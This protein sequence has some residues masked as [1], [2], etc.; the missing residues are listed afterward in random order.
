MKYS[1]NGYKRNSKDRNNPY[2]IIPS[3]NITMEGVDFPVLGTDNLGN[4]KLMMPGTNYVFPGNTVFEIPLAQGG[5]ETE[6][7]TSSDEFNKLNQGYLL[8]QTAYN[9]FINE[10]DT[11]RPPAGKKEK[12]ISSVL[13]FKNCWYNNSCVQTIKDVFNNAGIDS[14]IP[15]DVYDNLSFLKNYK[16][17]GFELI[18]NASEEDMR[19]GDII[20]F[21]YSEDKYPYH[22]GMYIADDQYISDGAHD[23]PMEKKSVS[24]K[25][26]YRVFR[27]L[28]FG[29]S[30]SKVQD[31]E[32]LDTVDLTDKKI[33]QTYYPDY[34]FYDLSKEKEKLIE[35]LQTDAF[36]DRY[37]KQYE[38]VTGNQ[39]TDEEYEQRLADQIA[40]I[41]GGSDMATPILYSK[42]DEGNIQVIASDDELAKRDGYGIYSALDETFLQDFLQKSRGHVEFLHEKDDQGEMILDENGNP[43]ITGYNI[44]LLGPKEW[45]A[46]ELFYGPDGYK[47]MVS[48]D[49]QHPMAHAIMQHELSHLY[50]T[51]YSPLWS[52]VE[53]YDEGAHYIKDIFGQ[54]QPWYDSTSHGLGHTKKIEEIGAGK[55]M[56][57]QALSDYGIWDPNEGEFTDKHLK[58]LNKVIRKNKDFLKD[59]RVGNYAFIDFSNNQGA[60]IDSP[61]VNQYLTSLGLSNPSTDYLSAIAGDTISGVISNRIMKSDLSDSLNIIDQYDSKY[62]SLST[63]K[64]VKSRDGDIKNWRWNKKRIREEDKLMDNFLSDKGIKNM[65]NPDYDI[66]YDFRGSFISD[67]MY[68]RNLRHLYGDG[69]IKDGKYFTSSD[70]FEQ[71][72]PG[73]ESAPEE[74]KEKYKEKFQELFAGGNL[75][76]L[77]GILNNSSRGWNYNRGNLWNEETEESIPY[78]GQPL[79]DED[80]AFYKDFET[81]FQELSNQ[82]KT[83]LYDYHKGLIDNQG[84][85]V[86]KYLNE[87]AMEEDASMDNTVMAKYGAELPKAQYGYDKNMVI[88]D[89]DVFNTLREEGYNP[90]DNS[91]NY[92]HPGFEQTTKDLGVY[93]NFYENPSALNFIGQNIVPAF[94]QAYLTATDPF[95]RPIHAIRG[96]NF[97]GNSLTDQLQGVEEKQVNEKE[98]RIS[99]NMPNWTT[100]EE[101][102]SLLNEDYEAEDLLL[103]ATAI[104]N[105]I[106][107]IVHGIEEAAEGDL[108][109]G[110]MYT[111]FGILPGTASP[112]VNKLRP[113]VGAL[114]DALKTGKSYKENLKART[115]A[116]E[117]TDAAKNPNKKELNSLIKDNQ[118]TVNKHL[119]EVSDPALNPFSLFDGTITEPTILSPSAI[120]NKFSKHNKFQDA[121]TIARGGDNNITLTRLQNAGGLTFKNGKVYI[122]KDPF[123]HTSHKTSTKT[124]E[125]PVDHKQVRNSTHFSSGAVLGH[126]AGDWG[127]KQVAIITNANTMKEAGQLQFLHPQDTWFYNKHALELPTEGSVILTRDKKLYNQILK[128]SPNYN[129]KF[130]GD[131]ID[132]FAKLEKERIKNMSLQEITDMFGSNSH[133]H[134]NKGILGKGQVFANSTEPSKNLSQWKIDNFLE[135][136][137]DYIIREDGM[138]ISRYTSKK[139]SPW[140]I[141]GL[142]GIDNTAEGYAARGKTYDEWN[143]AF[144]DDFRGTKNSRQIELFTQDGKIT[145]EALEIYMASYR[146]KIWNQMVNL[147]AGHALKVD[148]TLLKHPIHG[149]NYINNYQK[150][151]DEIMSIS[152]RTEE[153][154]GKK[155]INYYNDVLTDSEKANLLTG[156]EGII[157]R[158]EGWMNQHS[159]SAHRGSPLGDGGIESLDVHP[160][161]GRAVEVIDGEYVPYNPFYY[162]GK[163]NIP[164]YNK[165]PWATGF[166]NMPIEVQIHEVNKLKSVLDDD[167]FRQATSELENLHGMSWEELLQLPE[168]VN[169]KRKGGELPKAQTGYD[170]LQNHQIAAQLRE[171]GIDPDAKGSDLSPFSDVPPTGGVSNLLDI[172]SVPG[173]LMAEVFEGVGGYG[174][175]EFNFK[176]A[177]PGFSGDFSFTNMYDEPTK[178]VAGVTDVQGFIPSLLVNVFTDPT[179]YIGVGLLGKVGTGTKAASKTSKVI[180]ATDDLAVASKNTPTNITKPAA[181]TVHTPGSVHDYLIK[182]WNDPKFQK[183]QTTEMVRN[184][185]QFNDDMMMRN[186]YFKQRQDGVDLA[187][188]YGHDHPIVRNYHKEFVDPYP[189]FSSF[190][191]NFKPTFHDKIN[192]RSSFNDIINRQTRFGNQGMD[193]LNQK[194][195]PRTFNELMDPKLLDRNYFNLLFDKMRAPIGENSLQTFK[196]WI[197]DNRNTLGLYYSKNPSRHLSDK[198]YIKDMLTSPRLLTTRL[199]NP[200]A[201]SDQI[202]STKIHEWSHYL[203]KSGTTLSSKQLDDLTRLADP[204]T[205]M[206]INNEK[207]YGSKLAKD[208]FYY[209]KPTEIKARMMELRNNFNLLPSERFTMEHLKK[210]GN[211]FGMR[212]YLNVDDRPELFLD[213]MN[214]YYREGGENEVDFDQLERGIKYAE[215]L[216]GE[217]MKNKNSSASGFYGQLFSEIEDEYEGT[218]EDFI[219]DTDY[220]LE[221]FTKRANGE[222]EDV[223]GLISNGTD[224]Y[225]EYQDQLDLSKHGLNPLT[226]AG[227]SNMLGRQGTREYIGYVLRDGKTIEEVF[228]HLY[229][230]NAEYPNH[231]PEEYIAKFNKGLITKKEGGSTLRKVRRIKQQLKKYK[232]GKEISYIAKKE[233]INLGL[234]DNQLTPNQSVR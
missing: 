29:G 2:N 47:Q 84:E 170:F 70:T 75:N 178:T 94:H 199:S 144:M 37:F 207:L 116:K 150:S 201:Y 221:L 82:L 14:G 104:I 191:D 194:F 163:F 16:D 74:I 185:R 158:K 115:L 179:S 18:E 130:V 153:E 134:V 106:P 60:Y 154:L 97:F 137:S 63:K 173:N 203:D 143:A 123:I 208:Y 54:D 135:N 17:Y 225:S 218:R 117:I 132:E 131:Q 11:S 89:R 103:D 20:Q 196:S 155:W 146:E 112:I 30:L 213:I 48:P 172:L 136:N 80:I 234:I 141:E 53:G 167:V 187:L 19:M 232:E 10:E 51:K 33:E 229:G 67:Y 28:E 212:P 151:Y 142:K 58:K 195:K 211:M 87:I 68:G 81:Q 147:D 59:P 66:L 202:K 189:T 31:G 9:M 98:Q 61:E 228:P 140:K 168:Y 34:N 95:I 227:L 73:F 216:N 79:S 148:K 7:A 220:Q 231:T 105:P 42:D 88:Q 204:F 180:N 36:K 188:K 86:K 184:A 12:F 55:V 129:V 108:I 156:E 78:T 44:G 177:M 62:H 193:F 120:A 157:R 93:E 206:K 46:I 152:E 41:Q 222:L 230:E 223:P 109:S 149:P 159:T 52:G 126:S 176:D 217:L 233:L 145:D 40:F 162:R 165:G 83:E 186:L 169:M 101:R 171:K 6:Y 65:Q 25:G 226:I 50:N 1:K 175:K 100:W 69:E 133:N 21:H 164:I 57:E 160:E 26:E 15:E 182:Y 215:S 197:K 32:E 39:M 125:L 122:D 22:I 113:K 209:T 38:N 27:K 200:K 49:G 90:E 198:I 174:D 4:Q 64:D 71:N 128:E 183:Y 107:D 23:K 190:Y 3:G 43:I 76:T 124:G 139:F 96:G 181:T 111:L 192:Y 92:Q 119:M 110:A 210:S 138:M 56:F 127:G 85:N 99:R 35:K 121:L 214:K 118:N 205:R 72:H 5:T 166:E 13:P 45:E 114:M 77:V 219:K 8:G 224:L 24:G 91:L 161:T 102:G